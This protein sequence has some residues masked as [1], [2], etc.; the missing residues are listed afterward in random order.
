MKVLI[1]TPLYPPEIGGPATYSKILA[2]EL[3][4]R[5]V[6]VEI[7]SFSE[8]RPLPKIVRHI[9]YFLRCIGKGRDCEIIYAQ[10]PVS[11]GFPAVLAA[12]LMRKRFILKVVGDFAWEQYQQME[13]VKISSSADP[14]SGGKVQNGNSKLTNLEEFQ[15][16]RFDWKTE[17]RRKVERYVARQAEKVIVPSEYLKEILIKWGVRPE[18]II[19]IYNAFEP[20]GNLPP[21]EELRTKFGLTGKVLISAG[22]LVPWKGFVELI[23]AVRDLRTEFPD[24]KLFIAGDGPD[25][26]R[27][28]DL[29]SDLQITD[30][31][32]L[33]GELS[34]RDLLERVKAADTFVLNTGY[35]G[36]SHI[37]LEVALI[38][39]PIITT[40]VGGNKE[41]LRD[42]SA[43]KVGYNNR[44]DLKRAIRE[45]L[46]NLSAVPRDLSGKA[47]TK[48]T[49]DRLI[50]ETKNALLK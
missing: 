29:I 38:G 28:V 43:V 18:K 4:K 24:L 15:D 13:N 20:A 37:L 41:F 39:T 21:K 48:F 14:S 3:P 7:L 10:D 44:E 35:E 46:K 42:F 47:T 6:E 22:R 45:V 9:A 11:V 36:F 17:V 40:D 2:D 30:Q 25:M 27:L 12:K 26:G 50:S 16:E 49:R 1:A 19:V 8:V 23:R 32:S 34:R 5:A 33:L 31:V